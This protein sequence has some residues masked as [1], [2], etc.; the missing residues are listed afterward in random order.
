LKCQSLREQVGPRKKSKASKTSF[1]PI[2][3]TEGDLH[4]IEEMVHDVTTEALQQ[5]MEENYK[6]LG[7][8]EA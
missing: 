6:A 8:L 7:V 2:T 4:D 5:F 3:L 1:D